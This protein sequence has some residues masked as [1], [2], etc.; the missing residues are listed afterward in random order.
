MKMVKKTISISLDKET[1]NILE[2]SCKL[3]KRDKSSFI[4]KAIS[5]YAKKVIQSERN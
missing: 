5:E 2:K 4:T 1:I 3:D